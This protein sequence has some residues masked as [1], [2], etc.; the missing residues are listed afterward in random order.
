MSRVAR[1]AAFA[2]AAALAACVA[3][4]TDPFAVA[5][6]A[7]AARDLPAALCAYDAVPVDHARYPDARAKA[8]LVERDLRRSH[9][10]VQEA[11]GLRAE[12]RDRAAIAALQRAQQAWPT[13]PGL[14]VLLAATEARSREL[15]ASAPT[16]VAAAQR[17]VVDQGVAVP[18][19]P[20][21]EYA[22]V[23]APVVAPVAAD[24]AAALA[25]A[26]AQLA[27]GDAEAALGALLALA[28]RAPDE[29]RVRT[30]A[31]RLLCQRGL[32]RYGAGEVAAAIADFER[33]HALAPEHE[34][35]RRLLEQA[36]AEPR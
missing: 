14:D 36:R 7:F 26:E 6:Q 33:A 11:L 17:A 30:R 29:V 31:S 1:A 9:E 35:A 5:E 24:V 12:W 20:A 8:A 15:A 13:M 32:L 28:E 16:A 21:A 34:T 4:P 19:A 2:V 10:A 18:A 3:P 23:A 27:R 22:P 25:Q